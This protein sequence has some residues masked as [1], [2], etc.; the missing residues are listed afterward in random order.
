MRLLQ[1]RLVRGSAVL[2]AVGMLALGLWAPSSAAGDGARYYG[3]FD[4]H[5]GAG[6]HHGRGGLDG[7]RFHHGGRLPVVVDFHHAMV[8]RHW[9]SPL[10]RIHHT[11]V[12][13]ALAR[14]HVPVIIPG[15]FDH[16]RHDG[17]LGRHDDV[18]GHHPG[19]H[20]VDMINPGHLHYG[21]HAFNAACHPV[22]KIDYVDHG[23]K[24]KIVGMMCYDA[25]G[26]PYIVAG[27]RH[28]V[29]YY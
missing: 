4:H 23:R 1:A 2:A 24:A 9:I 25:L 15:R 8:H 11:N 27:S 28:I 7:I 18:H 22:S 19:H 17:Y 13:A 16:H 10:A 6:L 12:L 29:H 21:D 20:V 14:H 26:N 5:G 3:G